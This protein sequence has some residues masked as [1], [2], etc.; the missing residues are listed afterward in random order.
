MRS[1]WMRRSLSTKSRNGMKTKLV[2]SIDIETMTEEEIAAN[3]AYPQTP[4]QVINEVKQCIQNAVESEL[5]FEAAIRSFKV[6]TE[7]GAIIIP[8]SSAS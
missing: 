1:L 3:F 5:D 4:Q 7:Q 6:V 2:I 8:G